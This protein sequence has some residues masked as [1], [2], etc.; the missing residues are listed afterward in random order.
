MH[1]YISVSQSLPVGAI[2]VLWMAFMG[3]V[4][5]FPTTPQTD[6]ADMNYSVVVL[7]GVLILSVA[8]YYCPVYGGVREFYLFSILDFQ[9]VLIDRSPYFTDWFTGPVSNV[10]PTEDTD[11][12]KNF[13]KEH[14]FQQDVNPVE[15]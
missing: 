12:D 4:F 10:S 13:G 11:S 8:W 1:V 3:I 15:A 7:G 6:A 5:M 14:G 2:S 9:R